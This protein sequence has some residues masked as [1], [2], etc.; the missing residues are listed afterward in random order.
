MRAAVGDELLKYWGFSYGTT[1]GATYG[2]M[3]PRQVGRLVLDGVVFAPEQYS[4]LFAHGLSAGASTQD[5]L[6][7]GFLTLCSKAGPRL[8]PF[9]PSPSTSPQELSHL[10]RNLSISLL[11]SPLPLPLLTPP[12]ILLP[13][14]LT[15]AVFGS[16]YRPGSW[17]AL[18]L[19][20]NQTLEGD[21][22]ALKKIAGGVVDWDWSNATD[23]EKGEAKWGKGSGR[24]MGASEGGM[25]VSCGDVV[26]FGGEDFEEGW[27]ARWLEW[28]K[29]IV[30][31]GTRP[32]GSGWFEVSDFLLFK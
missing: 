16:L 6:E 1:L 22:H 28:E 19:A 20:L 17:A 18:A 25:A 9:S 7:K 4:S 23:L 32:G 29:D 12:S 15:S 13:S 8:C 10:L 27:E 26:P 21:G 24:E 11:D 3:Y 2:R 5:V 14:D 31:R 30:G